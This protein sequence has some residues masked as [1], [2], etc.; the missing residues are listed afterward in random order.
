MLPASSKILKQV[1]IAIA[2]IMLLSLP[3]ASNQIAK[4]VYN[5]RAGVYRAERTARI[6]K[7]LPVEAWFAFRAQYKRAPTRRGVF[8]AKRQTI[9]AL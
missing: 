2:S 1:L 6:D 4:T 3:N 9:S 7:A 8:W 5:A